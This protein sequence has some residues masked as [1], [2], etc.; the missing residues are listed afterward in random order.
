MYSDYIVMNR[1]GVVLDVPNGGCRFKAGN[2]ATTSTSEIPNVSDGTNYLKGNTAICAD[3]GNL[4]IGKTPSGSYKLD[5]NGVA[6][7]PQLRVGSTTITH[8]QRYW[9][10]AGS[11]TNRKSIFTITG[12]FPSSNYSVFASIM[13]EAPGI[14]DSFAVVIQAKTSTS[15]QGSICRVD[16]N[17]G[18]SQSITLEL[19][20]VGE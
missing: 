5:V 6:N 4:G 7:I 11:S 20:I 1:T 16:A 8:L 9:V 3:G 17:S 10:V 2:G 19:L 15:I 12:T 14:S 18:W 13:S